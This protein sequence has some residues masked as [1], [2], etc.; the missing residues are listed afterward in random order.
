MYGLA[1]SPAGDRIALGLEGSIYMFATDGSGFTRVIG[2]GVRPYWSADGSQFAYEIGCP[3][4][5]STCGFGIADA[6]GSNS[7]GFGY[8]TAGP[9]HPGALKDGAGG[10]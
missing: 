4:G 8:G 5:S 7:V 1:W 6:D 10:G 9:W 2:N 3:E